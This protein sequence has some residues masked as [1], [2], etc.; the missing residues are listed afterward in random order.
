MFFESLWPKSA[1]RIQVITENIEKHRILMDGSITLAHIIEAHAARQRAF[2]E[3]D[4]QHDFRQRQDLEAAKYSL[5]PV[6]YDR[7]LQ[8]LK[9]CRVV[10]SG[11]WLLDQ[12]QYINWIDP[13]D[14]KSRLLWL[15]G[16]PGA[17]EPYVCCHSLESY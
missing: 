17:G 12:E 16:I 14:K 13:S 15:Q 4:R 1:G 11:E 7:D 10:R 9:A 5:S 2:E 8:R 6:L 3:F